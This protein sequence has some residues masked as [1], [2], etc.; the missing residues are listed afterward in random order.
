MISFGQLWETTTNAKERAELI[1]DCYIFYKIVSM[2]LGTPWIAAI[3]NTNAQRARVLGALTDAYATVVMS[4]AVPPKSGGKWIFDG[5]RD[6]GF[7]KRG[8]RGK[9]SLDHLIPSWELVDSPTTLAFW[10]PN[11]GYVA[12][13]GTAADPAGSPAGTPSAALGELKARVKAELDGANAT[14]SDAGPLLKLEHYFSTVPVFSGAGVR[15]GIKK[16]LKR[17][18]SGSESVV[19]HLSDAISNYPDAPSRDDEAAGT[20]RRLAAILKP[21]TEAA[22][23]F[24]A[25]AEEVGLRRWPHAPAER[26]PDDPAAKIMSEFEDRRR[27]ADTP[28][29]QALLAQELAVNLLAAGLEEPAVVIKLMHDTITLIVSPQPQARPRAGSASVPLVRPAPVPRI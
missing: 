25:Y 16:Y 23:P 2:H 17:F 6:M 24:E 26:P 20:S 4:K 13:Q 15:G 1:M 18:E 21:R 22:D 9:A 27:E 19:K 12:A 8:G 28:L 29:K 5:S 10:S 14:A 3:P 7:R 11:A